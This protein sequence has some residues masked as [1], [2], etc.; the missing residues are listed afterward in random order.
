MI[1][2]KAAII[3]GKI[4]YHCYD[5]IH[6]WGSKGDRIVKSNDLGGAWHEYLHLHLPIL[7]HL[8]MY[9]R[10]TRSGIHNIIPINNQT[11][12]VL[13][14][15]RFLVYE[16][17]KMITKVRINNGSRPLRQGI[18]EQNG[19]VIYGEYWRN[20]KG[21]PARIYK[22]DPY[23][24]EVKV[25]LSLNNKRHIHFIQKDIYDHEKI[26]IGTG[27]RDYES[28]IYRYDMNTNSLE[29]IGCGS[30]KWRAVSILQKG[31]HLY[32]GSDCPYKQNHIYR[33]NR[34]TGVMEKTQSI[35]GPAYYSAINSEGRMFLAT[36]V[37][38]RGE[39]Q[40]VVYSSVDGETWTEEGKWQKDILPLTLL[41]FGTIEF[42]RG[43]EALKDVYINLKGLK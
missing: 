34:D 8:T 10:L 2:I 26:I 14:K 31:K 18:L 16:Q 30:Q 11:I 36:S 29:T 32:W 37:E 3:F 22:F 4:S 20:S 40:A 12:V 6:L 38:R 27:D 24:G 41:G 15:G 23:T 25:L 17:K 1:I 13:V 28:G 39:H 43:Q 21:E 19:C 9:N 33:Y 7:A 35:S 42:I 5:G